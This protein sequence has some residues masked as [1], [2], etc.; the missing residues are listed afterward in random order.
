MSEKFTPFEEKETKIPVIY[1]ITQNMQD[2]TDF[3]INNIQSLR[4]DS[5]IIILTGDRLSCCDEAVLAKNEA[6]EVIGVCT[7]APQGED[8]NGQTHQEMIRSGGLIDEAK[9]NKWEP[10]IVGRVVLP[11]YRRKGV[12][13]NL[14]LQ[15]V[16]R[17]QERMNNGELPSKKIR[18]DQISVGAREGMKKLLKEVSGLDDVLEVHN[19]V[20][21]MA[22]LMEA[23]QNFG[24][25]N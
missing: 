5:S 23:M 22:E 7:L 10:T 11:E 8:A 4:G 16:N 14:Y 6:G 15:A 18:I 24:L 1:E 2:V 17:M 19:L 13:Q 3:V 12:G 25:S 21:P 9:K 20:S